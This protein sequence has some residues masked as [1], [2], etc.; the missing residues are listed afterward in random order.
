MAGKKKDNPFKERETFLCTLQQK[1]L[2][3][4]ASSRLKVSRSEIC[5]HAIFDLYLN[6]IIP[7]IKAAATPQK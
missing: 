5:R 2:L 7:K 3:D 1:D 6:K 4:L